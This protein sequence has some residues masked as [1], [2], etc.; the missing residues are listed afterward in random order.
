M[1]TVCQLHL[2]IQFERNSFTYWFYT[3]ISFLNITLISVRKIFDWLSNSENLSWLNRYVAAVGESYGLALLFHMLITTFTLTLLAYQATQVKDYVLELGTFLAPL[4]PS[5]THRYVNLLF[6]DQFHQQI[7]RRNT[8]HNLKMRWFAIFLFYLLESKLCSVCYTKKMTLFIYFHSVEK[9]GPKFQIRGTSQN[10]Q[11]G[12]SPSKSN[13]L[14]LF[15]E[16]FV[17]IVIKWRELILQYIK[18]ES[19]FC[20]NSFSVRFIFCD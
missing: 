20:S 7:L 2:S 13:I 11:S 16:Q 12:S 14:S 1:I 9:P 19:S 18:Q 10:F 17:V 5:F 6:R 3:V 15:S 4:P 8:V